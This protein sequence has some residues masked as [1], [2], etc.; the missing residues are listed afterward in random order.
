MDMIRSERL[1]TKIAI[2]T[3]AGSGIGRGCALMFARHGARVMAT[4]LDEQGLAETSRLAVEEGL[5]IATLPSIDLTQEADVQRL[6]DT[7]VERFG[8]LNVLLNAGAWAAFEWIETMDYEKHWKRT[9]A[10]ELDVV[11][12][13][14]KLAWPH[15]KT[16]GAASIINFASANAFVALSG[17]PALAHCAGK[18]GVLAMTRQLAM[19]GA[20]HNIRANSLC[21]GMVVTGA[22]RPV[23]ENN[24]AIREAA[25]TKTMLGRFG[26]PEDVAWAAVFLASDES[27]WV[28]AADFS[29][30]GGATAW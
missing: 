6:V 30:D 17:S 7:T 9:L 13:A 8:Q 18:G 23:L 5:T 1:R 19:E 25:R 10:S 15:L 26:Q 12:L 20:P 11:F 4:D 14:C 28:T 21:P 3:G 29:I 22:T 2:V 27:S 24:P 16:S